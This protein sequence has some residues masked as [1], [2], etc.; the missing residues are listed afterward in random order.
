MKS[1]ISVPV[2]TSQF[3]ELVNFLRINND[4]R[5]PV[6]VVGTAIDYW[7]DN[8]NWKPELLSEI[9]SDDRGYQWKSLFLV[10]GTQI[11]MQYKGT[12]FYAKVEGDEIIYNGESISPGS[13]VNKITGTSRNAWRDLW[14]KSPGDQE[15]QLAL[16]LRPENKEISEKLLRELNER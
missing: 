4:P 2:Q 16:E 13:M 10:H 1:Q 12:T 11:R 7:L 6:D 3:L 14:I 5:D 8:A 9:S 15:W